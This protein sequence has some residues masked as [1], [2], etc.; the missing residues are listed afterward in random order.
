MGLSII[1]GF[2]F[3]Q[4]LVS[5]KKAISV[6]PD[7][8]EAHQA[9]SFVLLYQGKLKEGFEEYEWRWKLYKTNF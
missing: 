6:K 8:V 4:A 3:D 5:Y 7:Y 9:L 2:K 1:E